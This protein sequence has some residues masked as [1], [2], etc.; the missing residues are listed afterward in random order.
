MPGSR[1]ISFSVLAVLG[2]LALAL[3]ACLLTRRRPSPPP[4]PFPCRP[5]PPETRPLRCIKPYPNARLHLAPCLALCSRPLRPSPRASRAN[6]RRLLRP[7]RPARPARNPS[8]WLR[9]AWRR[10]SRDSIP[11][12]FNRNSR[13]RLLVLLSSWLTRLRMIY[14][15]PHRSGHHGM[16]DDTVQRDCTRPAR[17]SPAY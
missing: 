12:L 7:A 13:Q 10:H 11:R 6:L 3:P 4:A 14:V 9:P 1:E 5:C 15:L 17:N 8:R 2:S 16:L